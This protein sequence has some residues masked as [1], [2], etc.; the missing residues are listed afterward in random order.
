VLQ[1]QGIAPAVFAKTAN[2]VIAATMG[3]NA[4]IALVSCSVSTWRARANSRLTPVQYV[5]GR[6]EVHEFAR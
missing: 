2:K 3:R 5:E 6:R 1:Q 4:F